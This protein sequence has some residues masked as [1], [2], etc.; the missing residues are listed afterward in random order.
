[1]MLIA[2]RTSDGAVAQTAVQ[3]IQTAYETARFGGHEQLSAYFQ[4]RLTKAKAIRD[5]LKGQ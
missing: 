5:R 1:M 2:D 4:A 3:Q